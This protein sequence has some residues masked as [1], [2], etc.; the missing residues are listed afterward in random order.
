M[1]KINIV[2][3][4]VDNGVH[5]LTPDKS[6]SKN[7]REIGSDVQI[8]H[9]IK[10]LKKE[11]AKCNAKISICLSKKECDTFY[12]D[13]VISQNFPDI[14]VLQI[15]GKTRGA[16]ATACLALEAIDPRQP[17]LF[18]NGDQVLDVNLSKFISEFQASNFSAGVITFQ[19]THPRYSYVIEEAGEVIEVAEKR[20]ISD[21]ATCGY[22]IFKD[23]NCFLQASFMSFLKRSPIMD[24]YFFAPV[25]NELVLTDKRIQVFDVD[26]LKYHSLSTLLDI[27]RYRELLRDRITK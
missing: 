10:S 4:A 2:I 23:V 25:L 13:A 15:A 21:K 7:L 5:E 8:I 14:Q 26:P 11:T 24:N 27:E 18:V 9:V 17:V 16:L 1:R 20:P 6:Y 22:Y 19:S 12:T 3:L